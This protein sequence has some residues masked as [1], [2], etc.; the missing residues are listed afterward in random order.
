MAKVITEV[1]QAWL[2]GLFDGEGCVSFRNNNRDGFQ[3]VMRIGMTCFDAIVRFS[4]LLEQEGVHNTWHEQVLPSGKIIF[5]CAI[6]RQAAVGDLC[7]LLMP[8]SIVKRNDM[9]AALEVLSLVSDKRYS[10]AREYVQQTVPVRYR[11]RK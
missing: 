11:G 3:V 4:D 7:R 2:A 9:D 1:E 5:V 6:Q 8:Y 10:Q